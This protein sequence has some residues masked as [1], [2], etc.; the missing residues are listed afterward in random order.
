MEGVFIT[1]EEAE[2]LQEQ[3]KTDGLQSFGSR[4]DEDYYEK[5]G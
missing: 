5:R 2:E 1:E 4:K 3:L